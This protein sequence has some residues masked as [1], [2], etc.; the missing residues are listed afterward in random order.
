MTC[1]ETFFVELAEAPAKGDG[2][3]KDRKVL[4]IKPKDPSYVPVMARLKLV[5]FGGGGSG[6]QAD[7]QQEDGGHS[8][9][10]KRANIAHVQPGGGANGG[11]VKVGR[12]VLCP[13][14]DSDDCDDDERIDIGE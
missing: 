2:E 10:Q 1:G 3:E 7:V 9:G 4:K 6:G 11:K 14:E 12:Y 5:G 13:P 8:R